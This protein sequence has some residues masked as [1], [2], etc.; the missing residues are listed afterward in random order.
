MA[1]K[2]DLAQQ[3]GGGMPQ[4]ENRM[5]QAAQLA[6]MMAQGMQQTRQPEPRQEAEAAPGAGSAAGQQISAGEPAA[7]RTENPMVQMLQ[8]LTGQPGGQTGQPEGTYFT[9]AAEPAIGEDEVRRANDLLQKYKAGKAALDRRIVDNE[10]WFRMGHWKNY[11]NK[12]MEDKPKPSSGWLFNSIANKHADAM[13]NYPEPN[14]L[15]RA[16]D[17]EQTAKVL[18]KI[19]PTVLEQ[20]DYETAYSDTWWRKL[21]TGTGVKGVFWDP[22]LRGGLGD[23]SIRS[24]NVLMLYWEPGVEDIQDSPNLFSLSLANNDRLEGQYPQLKGHTGSSLDV[25]KYIHDDSVDTSDK[26]VVV[27][28][29]YKKALPGGQTVLHYCKFCNGV[30]LYASENDPAMADRGFYDHGKYP[31][32]FDPLFREEDSPAGFG[33]IDV[34]KDTQTAIDEMNHAMDEN[35]KLAAKQ[36]YVLSDTAGV[37]EEELADFGRDIVHVAGRLS[38]DSFRPLQVSGLQGNLITYRDD[39]VSEL[40]EISGNRDVSQGGT[41]SGLT[42]A[43][44]IA[45]LQEAGS[46]LSRDMLKSAYRAFAKECYLVI[47][48]MRQFY[49]E[50]RVYRITGESGGTEYVPFSNAALQAQPG[51]MVGG[52]QLGDHEPVFDITVT[53]A[54]KST[55]SRLSQNETAKEC[56]Q[57]G[58]FA[59]ANADAAMAALDMMDFE[60]IEKVRERVSQNGTLYQQLQQMAQQLQKMAAIID[61]QNGTNVAAAASAAGQAA[62]AAGGGSGGSTGAKTRTNSLGGAVGG[63]DDSLSTQAARR[64]MDVNNPNK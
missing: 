54:K 28:W 5:M 25:A 40:K 16:A 30:V 1:K 53:A 7:G 43:S 2:N 46:K 32:V 22:M 63:S 3:P 23:I 18:S 11:K 59:P 31:F 38:D 47:E 21:K 14:V 42:A 57:L 41:T 17:D 45:A 24:V 61:S 51:G 36:R 35:V 33:Y 64:A 26:S 15:P 56:Y 34:M 58:F 39:R 29:Y 62:G 13:D 9:A 4:D 52:V 20:C 60:G 55:F 49:D 10:L 19:L 6:A 27:D 37:N 44:A 12:M 48:L 8:S 50:Q